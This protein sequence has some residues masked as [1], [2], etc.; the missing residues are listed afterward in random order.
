MAELRVF[1]QDGHSDTA[2]FLRLLLRLAGMELQ[3]GFGS[4][5]AAE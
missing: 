1:F 2:A 3:R 5:C 4:L